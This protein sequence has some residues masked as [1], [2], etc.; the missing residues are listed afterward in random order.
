MYKQLRITAPNEQSYSLDF[1]LK[2]VIKQGK[3]RFKEADMFSGLKWHKFMSMFYKIEYGIY[4][5]F[6]CVG[7]QEMDET[8]KEMSHTLPLFAGITDFDKFNSNPRKIADALFL[9]LLENDMVIG[10]VGP[11]KPIHNVFE[12]DTSGNYTD[13]DEDEDEDG[14]GEEDKDSVLALQGWIVMLPPHAIVRKGIQIFSDGVPDTSNIHGYV[15]DSDSV[16]AYPTAIEVC[17]VS[18]GT[19]VREVIEMKTVD[20]AVF[21]LQNINLVSGEVNAIEYCTTMFN[22]PTLDALLDSFH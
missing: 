8:L 18:K 7:M 16:A 22:L 14:E 17:N 5:I 12:E 11:G 4:N 9:F 13:V 10:T 15:F 20:E 2:K 6:D 21:R 1:I 3:L 19:T